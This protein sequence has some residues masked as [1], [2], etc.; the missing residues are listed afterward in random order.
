MQPAY[1]AGHDSAR[2][3]LGDLLVT[4]SAAAAPRVGETLAVA[5]DIDQMYLFDGDGERIPLPR[6]G[7]AGR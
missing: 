4:V 5:T 2:Q 6:V 1:D 3:V 7:V